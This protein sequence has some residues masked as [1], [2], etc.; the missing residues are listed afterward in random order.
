M[1]YNATVEHNQK[2]SLILCKDILLLYYY[3]NTTTNTTNIIITSI[4]ILILLLSTYIIIWLFSVN[5]NLYFLFCSKN[6]RVIFEKE[7]TVWKLFVFSIYD[8]I[9]V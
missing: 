6:N 3:T 5:I 8:H 9:I 4:I 1:L 2:T 7:T